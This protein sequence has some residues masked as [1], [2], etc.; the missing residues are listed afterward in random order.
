MDKLRIML[1]EK[2]DCIL[3]AVSGGADSVALL[4]LL[5]EAAHERPVRLIAA[6]FEHGI[7]GED[8]LMDAAFVRDLCVEWAVPLV[9]GSADVPAL[10]K[11]R[12]IGLEQAAREA[13]YSFLRTAMHD[14]RADC[15]AL[16]HHRDDQVETVLMHLMRGSGLNGMTG[17]RMLEGDLYRPLLMYPKETLVSYLEN[18]GIAWREDVTNQADDTPRNGL[19]LEVIP[20]MERYYPGAREAIC[21]FSRI[22]AEDDDYMELETGRFMEKYVV[23]L[24]TGYLIR[25]EETPHRAIVMRTVRRLTG[26]SFDSVSRAADLCGKAR[27]ETELPGGW[28]AERGRMGLYLLKERYQN[29]EMSLPEEGMLDLMGLGR[30]SVREGQGSVVRDDPFCQEL[31]KRALEGAVVRTRRNGDYICPLGAGGRQK[32]S[33]YLINRHVDRPV[34]EILPLLAKGSEILWVMGEGI[35]EQ[36]KLRENSEAV[37]LELTGWPLQKV[38]GEGNA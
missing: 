38:G 3:V 12:R 24:P 6:H 22:A 27:G 16:A 29:T 34:R 15:I 21:R 1:P 31:S 20:R 14:V 30:L 17:M 9:E 25:M 10:A 7:R 4:S 19:R 37:R 28:R 26:V 13:R 36:A 11:E 8:S 5:R 33:D 23:K 2:M 18:Q 35:S 32:L